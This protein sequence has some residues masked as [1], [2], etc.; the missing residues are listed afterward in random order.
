MDPSLHETTFY[1][2]PWIAVRLPGCGTTLAPNQP[3][4]FFFVF[5]SHLLCDTQYFKCILLFIYAYTVHTKY[6]IT[7]KMTQSFPY[8]CKSGINS[9]L[10]NWQTVSRQGNEPTERCAHAVPAEVS[11]LI[12]RVTD[13]VVA[14]RY[15]LSPG[16]EAE[17]GSYCEHLSVD[18]GTEATA[19]GH[20]R[21]SV[22]EL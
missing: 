13:T 22:H 19:S 15:N 5:K 17:H 14:V 6:K 10:N 3:S 2:G 12:L 9:I 11:G 4:D 7:W 21:H 8:W 1:K 16:W 20:L 18:M